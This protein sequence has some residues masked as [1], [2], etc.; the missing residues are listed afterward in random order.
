M[1]GER[2]HINQES[3]HQ[4]RDGADTE[5]NDARDA[6][7]GPSEGEEQAGVV[8]QFPGAPTG[9]ASLRQHA[10]GLRLRRA[11]VHQG[12]DAAETRRQHAR[13]KLT[14]RERIA[15]LLD[16]GSFNEIETFRRHT[17]SGFGVEDRRPYT[18]G[19]ITGWGTVHGSKVFVFAHDFRIF[20]GSLGAAHATKIHKLMD[21]AMSVGAPV[22]GLNDGAGARIQEG[23]NALA[24]YGEIFR[25]N[26]AASGVI[27]Q[28]SV[29]LGPCAGGASYSPALTD[30][31]FMVRGTSQHVRDRARRGP[32]G[33]R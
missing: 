31:V 15:L 32:R 27:P 30:F 4:P 25:R 22:V 19:V 8:L 5:A 13:G 33:H 1:G 14:A 26:V 20:G 16:E 29:M 17:A 12:E 24:G 10:H 7:L 9:S 18:D 3:A 2:L 23:V 28:L 11:R 6:G 21:L